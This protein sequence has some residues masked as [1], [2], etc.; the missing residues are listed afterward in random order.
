MPSIAPLVAAVRRRPA[1]WMLGV[2]PSQTRAGSAIDGGTGTEIGLTVEIFINGAWTDI[3]P[4]VYYKNRV[5]I[6]RGR[7]DETAQVS[8][9]ACAF[10]INNRD[11][12]FSPR[13][14]VGPYYGQ[15]GRNTPVRVS[16]LQNGIRRF[17]FYG[18]VPSWPTTWDISGTDVY[19]QVS[20]SGML[21]RLSQGTSPEYSA[22]YRV[23]TFGTAPA[24]TLAYWPCEDADGSTSIASG[25]ASGAAVATSPMVLTGQSLPT[26]ANMTGFACSKPLPVI[27][28]SAWTGTI[29]PDPT[30][31]GQNV[32][33]FLMA[34]P[35]GGEAYNGAVIARLL[36][37]GTVA[38]VDL[39][40]GVGG[41]MALFGY[42]SAGVQL[43]TSG[44][45]GFG[46][47][48]KL[49]RVTIEI[50]TSGADLTWLIGVLEAGKPSGVG[51]TNTLSSSTVG[52]A[53]QAVINPDGHLGVTAFGHISYQSRWDSLYEL[54]D[55]LNAW[56]GEDPG[57]RFARL[58]SEQ[59][60]PYVLTSGGAPVDADTT[61]MGF[62]KPGTF[63]DLL[64]QTVD[65]GLGLQYETR[66]QV[67]LALRRRTS[68]YNQAAKLTLDYSANQLAAPLNPID[69]DALTRNDVTVSR[70]DGSSAQ[71][72]LA[73][74]ALSTQAPPAGVG[75]YPTS[76]GISL[77][78]DGQLAD[79][80]GWRLHMGTVDEPRF[81]AISLNLRHPT[82]T[83]SVDMMNAA[84]TIDVGDRLAVS[85]PP[86]WMP[87]DQIT[88]IVQGYS[89]TLGIFEHDM[90]L[91]CSPEDPYHV[92]VL[93]DL[94][95]GRA[96]TDG[97]TL[98]GDYSPTDTVLLVATAGAPA[99][100]LWTTS[101]P[102]FPFDIAAAGERIT[103]TG[104]TGSS[105]PQTF[106]VTRSINGVVKR[107]TAGTDVRLWQP[108][109]LSL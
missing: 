13:N 7:G 72:T 93:D 106:A 101:A 33:R 41:S 19:V 97:S 73:S 43:F 1:H 100:P 90:M 61:T 45:L 17:R 87:P 14:P 102:E 65:T 55:A 3:S 23:Y 38:R 10:T 18:E 78:T 105:S 31:S 57:D 89:E 42:N 68:L 75:D 81:P 52:I 95:L 108:M 83:G 47:D 82:F 60:V 63:P 103:V 32:L 15:I 25:L 48:G 56:T 46:V 109:I 39:Q 86:P 79:H 51:V 59:R 70:I 98:A 64:Q 58:C 30:V 94:V 21:R 36:T 50:L 11:G 88:Q 28:A 84:L 71:Q 76:Y 34:V 66:D 62:Q 91:V 69:D 27:N 12:R 49:L 54:A 40:Y 77:G 74:G 85:N 2:S 16:R 67:A 96:D 5:K 26:F 22:M 104:I 35:A 44:P 4:F 53:T 24:G 92:A 8:P 107:Q 20:A 37:A 29:P 9:Q 99:S 80:A 6:T